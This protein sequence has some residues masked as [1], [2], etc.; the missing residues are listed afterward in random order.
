MLGET[1][2]R[3]GVRKLACALVRVARFSTQVSYRDLGLEETKLINHQSPCAT[4]R[5]SCELERIKEPVDS[6]C[7]SVIFQT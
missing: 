3:C 1:S 4:L 5:I 6:L 7:E 2:R